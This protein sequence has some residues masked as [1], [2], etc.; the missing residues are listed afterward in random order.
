MKIHAKKLCL[1]VTMSTAIGLWTPEQVRAQD[2]SRRTQTTS[3]NGYAVDQPTQTGQQPALRQNSPF[4][5]DPF[6]G[7]PRNSP[8]RAGSGAIRKAAEA[9]RDAKGDDAKSAA[10]KKLADLLSKSY[11]EDMAQREREL[12][13]I[14]ERL[15]KLRDLLSRRRSKKQEII[16]LQIK[17]ALNEADGL[18]F[19]ENER[20][21][22][23][24]LNCY[25]AHLSVSILNLHIAQR[26]ADPC[27]S[28]SKCSDR[29]SWR[30]RSSEPAP[31]SGPEPAPTT[32]FNR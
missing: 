5:A 12:K 25:Y 30:R 2:P 10:Q 11:D 14:E 29:T 19:Y 31:S 26:D 9:V 1:F 3:R 16:D 15:T 28:D 21:A 32:D 18:G 6:Y 17:V 22:K 27:R 4:A 24:A 8:S 20:P 13:Q 7:S 23:S